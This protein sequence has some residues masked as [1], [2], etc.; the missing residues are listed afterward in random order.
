M[1]IHFITFAN[2]LSNFSSNRI[3]FEA[4]EMNIFNSV[5]C[6]TEKDFDDEYI[7]KYGEHFNHKR[8]YGYWSWKPYFLKK[9]LS[10]I[11]NGDIIVYADCGCKFIKRNIKTLNEWI[12][13]V[14]Q[15]D[16]G[17]FSPSFGPYYE[18]EWTRMDLFEYIDKKYNK[19]NLNIFDNTLQ[20]GAGVIF[21]RKNNNS[22]KFIDIWNDIMSNHFELCTDATSS[23]PNHP[24]FKENRHDQSVF[25]LLSKIF[26]ISVINSYDGVLN[27]KSTPISITR[28]KNDKY[29][30]ENKQKKC[31]IAFITHK[32]HL[33]DYEKKSFEKCMSIF[34]G[35]RDIKLI[36]PKKISTEFYENYKKNFEIVKVKNEWL[37]SLDSYNQMS[38]D[39][40]FWKMFSEYEYVLIY[41]TDCWVFEDNLDYFIEFGYD[42]YGAPWPFWGNNVGNSGL[43]LRN[44]NKMIEITSKYEFLKGSMHDDVWFCRTNIKNEMNICPWEIA[45]NFSLETVSNKLLSKIDKL[46]MG[47]HGKHLINLWDDSGDKFFEFKQKLLNNDKSLKIYVCTHKEFKPVVHS[48]VY[49]VVNA[50]DIND[51]TAP[52]GLKGS[53]Y[54][55]LM[56]YK[57]IAENFKLPKYVGFCCYRKYFY[58]LD[59][60]P[61][62]DKIFSEYDAICSKPKILKTNVKSQYSISHNI[63]DLY[64]IGGIIAEK[65]PEQAKMWNNFINGNILIPY[66]MFIMKKEDFKE[67]IN[68]IFSILDEY[69]KI[70]GTDI[71]K[72]IYDNYEK[73]IKNFYPNNTVEY[74]YRIGGY[75]AERLTNVFIMTHF[76]KIKTY[77]VIITEDKYTKK[78]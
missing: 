57:Y 32:S 56:T 41:Q 35:K 25:S 20:C 58:F 8:G 68:F 47:F 77:P 63:E 31:C 66:N 69:L 21:V 43:C 27:I 7:K 17:I 10:E 2:T 72:R 30:W 76:K 38:C 13:I 55:E 75:L 70:V 44:V 73:Y 11:D 34:E 9:K 49:K 1:K 5:T 14:S 78:G 4:Q 42:W 12:D 45:V 15:S 67:Y 62:I 24:N 29:T 59:D 33:N 51:D 71:N 6:F 54:S 60:I 26:K 61:D 46:P 48:N 36:I 19:D 53:F 52:N 16:S 37:D 40:E 18:Q 22:L 3:L 28:L 39:K 64:I 65:Y 50:N 74:Q 23:I